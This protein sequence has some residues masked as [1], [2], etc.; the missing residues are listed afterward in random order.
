MSNRPV[1]VAAG[2]GP[3]YWA[4]GCM[5]RFLITSE[6]AG[7]SYTTMEATVPPEEGANPH[8]HADEEEQFYVLDG[9]LTFEVDGRTIEVGT[10]DFL[11]VPR[12]VVHSFRNGDRQAKLLAT[13]V[14]GTGIEWAFLGM[15]T[16]MTAEAAYGSDR[17]QPPP[18]ASRHRVD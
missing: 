16:L 17:V 18:G 7:G 3:A 14:P 15:G 1:H 9:E 2:S 10:G 6:D 12:G 11:H 13:F 5:F 8:F 4:M